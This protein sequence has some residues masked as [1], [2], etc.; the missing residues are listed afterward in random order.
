MDRSFSNNWIPAFIK[1]EILLKGWQPKKK[2]TANL[3]F[4]E[5]LSFLLSKMQDLI[6]LFY[7]KMSYFFPHGL[8][9]NKISSDGRG[10]VLIFFSEGKKPPDR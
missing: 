8:I 2:T 1:K 7:K 9:N 3:L 5:E 4:K 10:K 6:Q